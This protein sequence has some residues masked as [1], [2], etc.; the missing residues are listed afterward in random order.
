MKSLVSRY[1][2]VLI[3]AVLLIAIAVLSYFAFVPGSAPVKGD[4]LEDLS[5]EEPTSPASP[6][7]EARLNYVKTLPKAPLPSDKYLF[8]QQIMGVGNVTLRALHVTSVGNY[9][10]AGSDCTDGDIS[11]EN[12]T[13]GIVKSD[14]SGN[15]STIL[16]LPLSTGA[17]YLASQVTSLGIVVVCY[18]ENKTCLY[19]SVT[20]YD[21]TETAVHVLSY[22]KRATV[23]PTT[24]SFLIFCE[25]DAESVVYSYNGGFTFAAIDAFNTVK[26]FEY[27]NYYSLFCNTDD[28]YGIF[29]VDKNA[30][31]L[32]REKKIVGKKLI[33]V[34]PVADNGQKFI[35]IESASGIY[36]T[37]YDKNYDDPVTTKIGA[38]EITG[39]GYDGEKVYLGVKGTVGGIVSI[40]KD[41]KCTFSFAGTNFL[42]QKIYDS[43]YTNGAFYLVASDENGK[44]ALIKVEENSVK[45]TYIDDTDFALLCANVNGTMTVVSNGKYYNYRC[46]K[47]Y[48]IV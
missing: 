7:D 5:Y 26:M 35:A 28:G 9:V 19:V 43:T 32:L 12:K 27:G 30:F 47:Y 48:G 36:A 37:K 38:Y 13:V 10:I 31:T 45:T 41:L 4:S 2:V 42:P 17:E 39:T 21:L 11:G 29:D 46:V 34:T 8:T 44:T 16:T 22:A 20:D 3:A 18:N 33:D 14:P 15:V 25:G 40:D 24:D 6:V 1:A 23:L